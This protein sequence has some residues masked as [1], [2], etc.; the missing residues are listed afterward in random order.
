VQEGEGLHTQEGH[1]RKSQQ[2]DEALLVLAKLHEEE[3]R[4]SSVQQAAPDDSAASAP[5]AH[6]AASSQQSRGTASGRGSQGFD[7]P[8]APQSVP[9]RNG[10][11]RGAEVFA[12]VQGHLQR[13]Q[14]KAEFGDGMLDSVRSSEMGSRM[15][16]G[17]LEPQRSKKRFKYFNSLFSNSQRNNNSASG[18]L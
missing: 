3:R 7:Y 8:E 10:G 13:G 11:Q 4:R 1:Q 2:D 9:A 14:D 16:G 12:R 15:G 18:T 17:I 6:A 5:L